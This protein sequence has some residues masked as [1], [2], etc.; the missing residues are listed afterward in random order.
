[1]FV[2]VLRGQRYFNG[3]RIVPRHKKELAGARVYKQSETMINRYCPTEKGVDLALNAA[4]SAIKSLVDVLIEK[5]LLETDIWNAI[6][7]GEQ[8]CLSASS[9]TP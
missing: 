3:I 1:M 2:F 4:N 9:Y 6:A 8:I 7:K 5:D